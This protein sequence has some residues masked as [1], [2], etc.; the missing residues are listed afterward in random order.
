MAAFV[1]H[2]E[3]E[4]QN[5]L[6]A[7]LQVVRDLFALRFFAPA[8]LVERQVR[9]DQ[10]AMVF[11]KPIDSVVRAASFFVG[12]ESDNDVAV[13]LESFFFVL[14]EVGDPDSSLRLVVTGAAPVK[15]A[16]LLDELKRVSAP[17]FA[18]GFNDIDVGE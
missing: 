13:G 10:I 15:E 4:I 2:F 12:G 14:D 18:L 5:V 7:Y 1:A 9:L 6:F 16:V 3:A 11:Q 17:V 8:A